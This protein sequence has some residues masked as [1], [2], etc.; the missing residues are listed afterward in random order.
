[1]NQNKNTA[2]YTESTYPE[3]TTPEEVGSLTDLLERDAR[4]NV[5]Q[6]IGNC[7]L[8]F[9]MDELLM[10][11]LRYNLLTQRIDIVKPLG[12]EREGTALNDIDEKY[13]QLH[14]EECYGLTNDKKIRTALEITADKNSYHPIRDYLNTLSWDGQERIRHALHRYLGAEEDDYTYNVL[15]LFMLGAIRRAFVPGCKFEFM[16]CL[17]GGQGAGKSSFFRLMAVRDEWFSDD[18]RRLEDE[19]VYRK[20]QGHWIIEMSEMIAT[21][22]ARSIEEIKSFLSRQ[23]ETYKVPYETHPKDRLR[24]CVFGGTSNSLDFLPLDRTGNRRFMPVLVNPDRAEKHLLDDEKESREYIDQMWAE[25]IAICRSG[26]YELRF[27]PEMQQKVREVQTN[28]MPEDSNAGIIQAFLDDF[29]G[30]Y[31]CTLLLYREALHGLSDT[32]KNWELREISNIM[33]N[34]ITGWESAAQHR[35]REYGQQRSWKRIPAHPLTMDGF[36]D[37]TDTE[38]LPDGW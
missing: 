20:L 23:K 7:M 35:F 14:M 25:A 4:G 30:D 22:S 6:S 33:N 18:L 11:S 9:E 5:R 2:I 13:I 3:Q 34:S 15:K 24:Q 12:W 19:N 28:F 8:V 17:V 21:A 38:E 1:M 31:V 36:I 29:K 16:L 37:V 26:D 27:S 32:P 10:G